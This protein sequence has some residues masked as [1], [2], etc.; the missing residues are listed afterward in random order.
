MDQAKA[1][2][3][4]DSKLILIDFYADWCG[5]CKKMDLETWSDNDVKTL[6]QKTVNARIDIDKNKTL[7]SYY[8]V[9]AI[10]TVILADNWGNTIYKSVG[11]NT[12]DQVNS[13]LSHVPGDISPLNEPLKKL[14]EDP[15]NADLLFEVALA[16]QEI[17]KGLE[18]KGCKMF[19]GESNAYL[20]KANRFYK[21]DK[22]TDALENVGL[23]QCYNKILAG[24]TKLALKELDKMD[25]DQMQACNKALAC[26]VKVNGYMQSNNIDKAKECFKHLKACDDA[27]KYAEELKTT[28][29]ELAEL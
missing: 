17:G 18:K 11:Y 12:A 1:M 26:F 19:V 2:A 4:S 5:P 3:Q 15:K 10:P 29:S 8:G 28:F 22:N 25:T 6:M 24:Q 27:T 21:K 23:M 13:L 14:D 16:Y 7:A 20:A 9:K